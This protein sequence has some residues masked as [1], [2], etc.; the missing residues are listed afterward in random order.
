MRSSSPSAPIEMG[1]SQAKKVLKLKD[2]AAERD[3]F[4]LCLA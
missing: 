4:L 3:N 1:L 2:T